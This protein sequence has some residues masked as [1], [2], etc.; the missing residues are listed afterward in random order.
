M[1]RVAHYAATARPCLVHARGGVRQVNGFRAGKLGDGESIGVVSRPLPP[2]Q[3]ARPVRREC[4]VRG[5]LTGF[6]TFFVDPAGIC[7]GALAG[8]PVLRRGGGE[9]TQQ[10]SRE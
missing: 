6:L 4:L 10:Q 1:F 3:R 8:F 7:R 2:A 9:S 5:V